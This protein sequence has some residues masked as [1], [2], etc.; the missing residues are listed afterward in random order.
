[1]SFSFTR[2]DRIA[3]FSPAV[4]RA[5]VET[6]TSSRNLWDSMRAQKFPDMV[7]SAIIL[8]ECFERNLITADR[9]ITEPGREIIRS[10]IA[11]RTPKDQA[12]KT[13]SRLLDRVEKI[14]ADPQSVT[15]VEQ[16]WMFGSMITDAETVGDIDL[17]MKIGRNPAFEDDHVRG[18]HIFTQ[19]ESAGGPA[20]YRYEWDMETWLFSKD[21][22]GGKKWPLIS[23]VIG[24]YQD[25]IHLGVPCQLV[26][27]L[28]RGGR[29]DDAV[30][31]LHPESEGR[32]PKAP[33]PVNESDI[34][35]EVLRPIDARWMVG[36]GDDCSVFPRSLLRSRS[37]LLTDLF[38]APDHD[39][40]YSVIPCDGDARHK[41]SLSGGHG[42]T[43]YSMSV[44]R[45]ITQNEDD[46]TLSVLFGRN[47]QVG[48]CSDK[49]MRNAVA[50]TAVLLLADIERCIR[51][52][53]D[54]DLYGEDGHLKKVIVRFQ[55]EGDA[56]SNA[57]LNIALSQLEAIIRKH[58]RTPMAPGLPNLPVIIKR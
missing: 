34:M 40:S 19:F 1:M 25:I 4:I 17:G 35:P 21:L 16:V 58:T 48:T 41:V 13:L 54:G 20:S 49:A 45:S 36:Y 5:G 27:D 42:D 46:V 50:L 12:R 26:Y 14:N 11:A 10:R 37:G 30:L 44:T 43:S 52:L 2:S 3:G 53:S 47:D 24:G 38:P 28:D 22:F 57:V 33:A 23:G 9:K 39:A 15:R 29:V 51:R 31:P 56:F 32:N 18:E 55:T 8:E 7:T 6:F